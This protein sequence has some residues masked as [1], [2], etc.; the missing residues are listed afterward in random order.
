[1]IVSI[2][3]IITWFRSAYLRSLIASIGSNVMISVS[4]TPPE[5]HDIK[6]ARFIMCI[7]RNENVR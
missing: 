4:I 3:I 5:F 6:L 2:I 7:N 1:M